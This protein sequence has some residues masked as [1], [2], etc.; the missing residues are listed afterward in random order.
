MLCCPRRSFAHV[1]RIPTIQQGC[2]LNRWLTAQHMPVHSRHDNPS[3]ARRPVLGRS[4]LS[5]RRW[6]RL[7][8]RHVQLVVVEHLSDGRRAART[9]QLRPREEEDVKVQVCYQFVQRLDV[10]KDARRVEGCEALP[11]SATLCYC[12]RGLLRYWHL[13]LVPHCRPVLHAYTESVECRPISSS[14]SSSRIICRI[15]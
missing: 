12:S 3:A 8:A 11:H 15:C 5:T 14:I 13:R 9:E 4:F 10:R 1:L 2:K 6:P 7:A